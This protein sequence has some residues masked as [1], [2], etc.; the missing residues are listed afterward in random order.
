M[1]AK[2]P[3]ELIPTRWIATRIL[4]LGLAL[5][6]SSIVAARIVAAADATPAAVSAMPAT[7]AARPATPHEPRSAIDGRVAILT[8]ALG[9]SA[10]QQVQL[11]KVLESGRKQINQV[12]SD[13]TVP[14]PYRISATRAIEEKTADQI[15]ALLNDDQK[16]KYNPPRQPHRMGPGADEPSVED[17]MK[18]TQQPTA[19]P[20]G[21]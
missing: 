12:W 21:H 9:L 1:N 8:R 16:K 7:P 11:T 17:W 10:A 15:R 6:A 5:A 20:A 3:T 13:A 19:P 18:A 2:S 4:H 14:A